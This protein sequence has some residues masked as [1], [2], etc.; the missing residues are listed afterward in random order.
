MVRGHLFGTLLGFW[1]ASP[2]TSLR[3]FMRLPR[4]SAGR[5]FRW[6]VWEALKESMW[7]LKIRPPTPASIEHVSQ[8]FTLWTL[9]QEVHLDELADDDILCTRL[10]GTTPQPPRTGRSFW[11]WSSP[12]WTKWFG[13]FGPL[14]KSSS[15]LG[16]RFKIGSGLQTDCRGEAGQ[17]VALV[18]CAEGCRNAVPIYSS[19]V[20]SPSGS[21]TW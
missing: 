20:A 13:R 18:P 5:C 6:K 4:G 21:G 19:D 14:R 9:L 7:I 17:T 15:L 16:S 8:F 11:A 3:S 2:E 12:P 1:V 10:P